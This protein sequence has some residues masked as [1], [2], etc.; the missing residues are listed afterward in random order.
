MSEDKQSQSRKRMR[1]PSYPATDLQEAIERAAVVW[2]NDRNH[3]TQ[4]KSLSAHWGF[5]PASSSVLSKVAALKHF[6]LM[7]EVKG[8]QPGAVKLSDMAVKILANED[9]ASPERIALIKQA[10]LMPVVFAEL[11]EK[12]KG[13]LPS[14]V[15]IK[16]YLVGDRSFN[17]DVVNG[18]IKAF[19][20]TISFAGLQKSDTI[21][22]EN[23]DSEPTQTAQAGV[24][25]QPKSSA[26]PA[27]TP[28]SAPAK[29]QPQM[30]AT[31]P[32]GHSM[33]ALTPQYLA[34]PLDN[35]KS[36]EIPIGMEEDTFSLFVE[37]LQL[38]K[39]RIIRPPT[40]Q[41]PK[42]SFP[43]VVMWK[44]K[45]F[46][47]MVKITGVAGEHGGEKYYQSEDGT[48]IPASELFPNVLK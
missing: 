1:S 33:T 25:N 13:D 30:G 19:K 14:D 40:P 26:A 27:A 44:N 38:W 16:T 29:P 22:E 9:T 15:T 32:G 18:L 23:E 20:S 10:A 46:D 17:P 21:I 8:G 43:F 42:E 41:A 36:V 7:D 12:Y 47:K 11:W 24:S 37:T 5:N 2:K 34:I 28:T 35:G 6:G 4:L 3:E 39:K 48:G 45:D 31:K